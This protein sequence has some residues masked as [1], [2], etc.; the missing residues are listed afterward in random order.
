MAIYKLVEAG[1]KKDNGDGSVSFIPVASG[2]AD[3]EEYLRWIAAGN[4]PDPADAPPAP[5]TEPTLANRVAALESVL[6]SKS[7]I[8]QADLNSA[9]PVKAMKVD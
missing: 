5:S 7:I 6:V 2:N 4:T 1:I 8:Q 3:Y 9:L